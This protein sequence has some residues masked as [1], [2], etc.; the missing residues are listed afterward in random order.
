MEL[1]EPHHRCGG[2]PPLSGE[3]WGVGAALWLP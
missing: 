1:N 2:P 3:A